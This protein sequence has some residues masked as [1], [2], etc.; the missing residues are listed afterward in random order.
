MLAGTWNFTLEQGSTFVQQLIWL[1]DNNNPVN[2]TGCTAHFQ[3]R[4]GPTLTLGETDLLYFDGTSAGGQVFLGGTNG[5]ITLVMT[6]DETAA[7]TFSKASYDL[8][9]LFPSGAVV[10][11]LQGS[12]TLSAEI[13]VENVPAGEVI[14]AG[15]G[16]VSVKTVVPSQSP[17]TLLLSDYVILANQTTGAITLNLPTAVGFNDVYCIVATGSG[18]NLVTVVPQGTEKISNQNN[19]I[20][21]A[22]GAFASYSSITLISDESN[23]WII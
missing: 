11:L 23:W 14:S 17:Y 19:A 21:G 10:R 9:I 8:H 3:F 16:P 22:P 6:A 2:L 12:V 15:S 1:D 18:T 4:N 7:M 13:T 20:V 5:S